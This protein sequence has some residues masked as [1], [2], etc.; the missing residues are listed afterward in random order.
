MS[1]RDLGRRAADQRIE[2]TAT[3]RTRGSPGGVSSGRSIPTITLIVSMEGRINRDGL[4]ALLAT[5]PDFRVLATT[6]TCADVITRC[7]TLRPQVLV[8]GSLAAWPRGLS[9]VPAIRL[10]SPTTQV[11]VLAPHGR[12]RCA[13]LNPTDPPP[14]D[15]VPRR[16]MHTT[17][18]A[19][20]LSS[21]ALGVADGDTDS[22]TLFAA[23]RAVARGRPWAECD[24]AQVKKEGHALSPQELKVAR[25]VGRGASNKEIAV[26]MAI[27]DLTVKKHLGSIFKKL[28][29]H[30][31]LQ[32]GVCVARNPTAFADDES[33]DG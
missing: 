29:L 22:A 17:C 5:Q 25:R 11:L 27:S 31:R 10:A 21:G 23:V 32:L 9:I 20:A 30:D 12:D 24:F 4:A 19:K 15:G 6:D 7:A 13:Y 33:S 18:L 14:G 2:F 3:S 8:L 1:R 16:V 28:G 26:G